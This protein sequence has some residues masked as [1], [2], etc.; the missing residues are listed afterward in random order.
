MQGATKNKTAANSPHTS[1]ASFLKLFKSLIVELEEDPS[2][3]QNIQSLMYKDVKALA[4]SYN[5]ALNEFHAVYKDWL[6]IDRPKY[7]SF[8]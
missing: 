6:R 1:K 2:S 5:R 3:S 8:I 7:Y 4:T